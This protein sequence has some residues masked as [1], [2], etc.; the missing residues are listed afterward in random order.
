MNFYKTLP[1]PSFT[2]VVS[3]TKQEQKIMSC[4]VKGS[5]TFK[6]S[7]EIIDTEFS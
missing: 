1:H 4:Y 7:T 5:D 3:I 6:T 2:Q